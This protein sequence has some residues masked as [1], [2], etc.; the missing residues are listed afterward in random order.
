MNFVE[1]F[2]FN[3]KLPEI[4]ML[5]SKDFTAA[6]KL[7]PVGL[8]LMITGSRDYAYPTELAWHV[9]TNLRPLEHF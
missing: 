2:A 4:A 1:F 5:V 8:N 6:K 9:F 7:P 3:T